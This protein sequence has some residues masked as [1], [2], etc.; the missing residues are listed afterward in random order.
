LLGQALAEE[1]TLATK[2]RAHHKLTMPNRF[3]QT[4]AD[5]ASAAEASDQTRDLVWA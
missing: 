2:L 5:I 4:N 3:L 1:L